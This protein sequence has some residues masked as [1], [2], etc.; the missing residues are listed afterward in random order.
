MK[1]DSIIQN[2]Q[3]LVTCRSKGKPKRQVAMRDIGLIEN[4]ALAIDRGKIVGVGKTKEI[5]SK[6]EAETV[7]E[8]S[9]KTVMP[10]FVDCHTHIVFAGNR[11]DEFEQKIKGANYLEILAAGGGIISTVKQTRNASENE[12][13]E[14]TRKR[15]DT[16]LALGTTTAEV[17]TGYGLETATELKMLDVIAELDQTHFLDLVPT[18]LAAHAIPPEL[19]GKTDD[20]VD[21]ICREMLPLARNWYKDLHFALDKTPFFCDVFCEQN[22]FDLEQSRRVLETAKTLGLGLK[23]HVDEFNNLG[24]ARMAI[25]IGA[26]SIDHLDQTSDA[27]INLLANSQTIPVVTPA[28]NFNFGSKEFADARKLID[29]GCAVAVSTD[30]NP[31]SAPCPGLPMAMAIA[32]RYQKLLPSEALNAAIIN[33]A[34]AVGLGDRIGSLEVGK[35]ADVLILETNDYREI[36]YE[37]GANFVKTVIKKGRIVLEK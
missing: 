2:A 10:G 12:L 8:A 16:M 37:L 22:A 31:G 19:K 29:K 26:T 1:V 4:G 21:L 33:A 6:F 35:Q 3:Q 17:K 5:Q 15:L 24:G 14:Q 27:E 25:E 13:S 30:Y 20:Y 34:F 28:V 9:G 36:A 23:A 7:I 18:F 11:L 32:C